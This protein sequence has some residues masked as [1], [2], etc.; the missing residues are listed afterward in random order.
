MATNQQSKRKQLEA[1]FEA[2]KELADKQTHYYQSSRKL[3]YEGLAKVYIWWQTASKETGLLESIYEAREIQ[4][5]K[6][7]NSTVNFSPLLRY[8]WGMD[9]TV[10]S[11]IIDRWNRALNATHLAVINDKEYYKVNTLDKLISYISSSGVEALAGY[12]LTAQQADADEKKEKKPK[13]DIATET[14]LHHAHL[15][16]GKTYFGNTAKSVAKFQPKQSLA[17]ADSAIGLALIRKT[18]SGYEVLSTIEDKELIE[19]AIVLSYKRNTDGVPYTIRLMAEVIKTQSLPPTLQNLRDTLLEK[20]SHK[21]L[22]G[23]PIYR[24]TRLLYVANQ[25]VFV[26]SL[27]RGSCS[28]VTIAVPNKPI[29]TVKEDVYLGVSDS[30]YIQ[31]NLIYSGNINFFDTDTKEKLVEI[32][33][34]EEKA[35]FKI[36]FENTITKKYRFVRFYPITNYG[37]EASKEQP[38][39]KRDLKF[40]PTF[41]TKVDLA[42]LNELNANF[43]SRWINGYGKNIKRPQHTQFKLS[44]TKT[45]LVIGYD[46]R[47]QKY[48]LNVKVPVK[49]STSSRNL[50]VDVR[51][52]DIVPVL[53]NLV[54]TELIGQLAITAD[55]NVVMFTYKTANASFVVAV[56]TCN[57][58]GK[59]NTT[60]FEGYGV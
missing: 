33:D 4:Y 53:H 43:L 18:S 49:S 26:L 7:I 31:E 38:I 17:T 39:I 13:L 59:L 1:D 55:A 22:E 16:Q 44:F 28:V 29:M 56:P 10:N 24:Y 15:Q 5:K 19:R 34:E 46:Y 60:Y 8:L 9:G 48:E 21:T 51:S 25:K 37:L 41:S 6:E 42:W 47:A 57:E 52:K 3:L 20:S 2:L 11:N 54:N 50:S 27:S 23:K 58:K 12:D 30:K 36:Q 35:V 32:K 45:G 14:R 40:K